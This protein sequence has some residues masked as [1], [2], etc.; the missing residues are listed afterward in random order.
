[1]IFPNLLFYGDWGLFALRLA[2]A[3]VF[4]VHGLSKLKKYKE[5]GTSMGVPGWF[6]LGLGL[7][8]CLSALGLILGLYVQLAAAALIA[9]MSG[10]IYFKV[11]KWGMKFTAPSAMGWEFDFILLASNLALLLTGGGNIGLL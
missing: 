9:V 11:A 3:A 5:M 1:M 10:A 7:A 8:E 4:L 6:I 2:V